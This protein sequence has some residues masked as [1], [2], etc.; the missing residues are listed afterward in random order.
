LAAR[1]FTYGVDFHGLL[2]LFLAYVLKIRRPGDGMS[3]Q[4]AT[5]PKRLNSSAS[6]QAHDDLGLHAVGPDL[7]F[8][9]L[10]DDRP[11]RLGLALTSGQM[12]NIQS[13]T[14][15]VI[16]GISLFGGR[17]SIHGHALRRADRR[18]LSNSGC[19]CSAPTR[20]GPTCL[21]ACSSSARHRGPVDQKGVSMMEPILKGR[22]LVKRYGR[23][24]ALD[25]C[26]FDLHPVKSWR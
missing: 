8:C 7:R 26:D 6:G 13:I 4:W 10:G 12:G 11:L 20:N 2:V 24:V 9:R 3:M 21:S 14:A 17:G 18:R 25:N 1:V 15:V 5:I 23:V 16:G 19:A 22:N